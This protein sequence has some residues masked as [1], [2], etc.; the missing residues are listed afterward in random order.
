MSDTLQDFI[1]KWGAPDALL[2]DNAK[3][4]IS[5]NVKR[6]LREYG[7]KNQQTEPHHPN[8]NPAERRIQD[9]KNLSNTIM[10]RT[11]T[12]NELWYL[13]LEYVVYLLNHLAM[14]GLKWRTPIEVATGETPDISNLLQFHWYERV[15]YYDPSN[16]YPNP[17]EKA[18]RFVGI[19]ENVGDT[20]TYK[21]ITDD[22]Q[23]IIYRSVVRSANDNKNPNLRADAIVVEDVDE[24]EERKQV[25][26]SESDVRDNVV[27]PE[28][29]P[30]ELIGFRFVHEREDGNYR[31]EVV[32]QLEEQTDKYLVKVGGSGREEI[33]HYNDIIR[34]W[35]K[36]QN[37]DDNEDKPWTYEDI[38]DHRKRGRM[39]EIKVLWEDGSETWEP[40]SVFSRDDPVACANYASKNDILHL[41]GWR[42]FRRYVQKGKV[43]LRAM[44]RVQVMKA[45]MDPGLKYQF[46]IRVPRT[47]R[48]AVAID[49]ANGNTLWQ[50]AIQKE[51]DQI[52]EYETFIPRP[53]LKSPPEG[54]QF[55]RVHFVFA[56][57]HDLR[58]KARLVAG[59]HMTDP[60]GEES[61]SSVVTIKGMRLCIF[62]AELNDLEIMAG[63]V[64]NAYL[65][66]K[67]RELIYVI[68][69][70]EFGELEGTILIINK[71]L[72]G[73]KTSGARY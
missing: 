57:K 64:G 63:D 12:P 30:Q 34:E 29:D 59:G 39:N 42:R 31:V 49:K 62:L 3:T 60:P 73:L 56:V 37:A 23:Q 61:Y 55:V 2:S 15:Y 11:N 52:R 7:I 21:I 36:A 50:D 48:E 54:Y 17:K 67:T 33:L 6:I 9:V 47:Y 40:L 68:A 4:Q 26:F 51:L 32:E 71:A 66:A 46:G 16:P 22:T 43:M 58:R 5:Q 20:L 24:E 14:E 25:I 19:A 44:R 53:D 27:Y 13:A 1:R 28:V 8:Q 65:E 45:L 69:G 41:P 18:G 38:I 70:P 10:D 72:Y 35:E